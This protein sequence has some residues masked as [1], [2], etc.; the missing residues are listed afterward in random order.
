MWVNSS[1]RIDE[2]YVSEFLYKEWCEWIP[3][4]GVSD[5]STWSDGVQ[6][7]ATSTRSERVYVSEFLYSEG[8][9]LCKWIPLQGVMWVNSSAGS[10]EIYVSEFLYNMYW[11]ILCEWIPL[12]GVMESMWEAYG[13]DIFSNKQ[14]KHQRLKTNKPESK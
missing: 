3:L 4:Q 1:T 14:T 5:S 2:I 9:N 10:D 12:Q 6:V 11:W 7:S 8:W 13:L